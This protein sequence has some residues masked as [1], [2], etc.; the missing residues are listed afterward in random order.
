M[1]HFRLNHA[2]SMS[3]VHRLNCATFLAKLASARV[4]KDRLSQVALLIFRALFESPQALCTGQES[5]E[6][7]L[8]RGTKQLAV[9][10]LIP[11]AIAWL[12]IASHNL[13]LL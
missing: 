6:E 2:A 11:A 7:D 3:G 10:H 9:F 4:A 12:K 13:L 1:S 8:K 5:D